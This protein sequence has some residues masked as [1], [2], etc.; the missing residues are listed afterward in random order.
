LTDRPLYFVIFDNE[1]DCITGTPVADIATHR[2][3]RLQLHNRAVTA[4]TCR[5]NSIHVYSAVCCQTAGLPLTVMI[6]FF[7]ELRRV[8]TW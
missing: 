4:H 8:T 6:V 2:W 1:I 5:L 3:L 7:Q